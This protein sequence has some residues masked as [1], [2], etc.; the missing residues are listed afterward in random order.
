MGSQRIQ[1]DQL[2]LLLAL[3]REKIQ[4]SCQTFNSYPEATQA[5]TLSEQLHGFICPKEPGSTHSGSRMGS[6]QLSKLL[7]LMIPLQ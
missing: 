7:D 2:T 1:L 6:Y 3:E 4:P 5:F